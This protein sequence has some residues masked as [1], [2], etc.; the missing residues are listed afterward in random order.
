[1][2]SRRPPVDIRY[3][4]GIVL[5]SV[6]WITVLV[7]VVTVNYATDVHLNTKVVDNIKSSMVLKHDATSAIYIALERLL[8]RPTTASSSYNLAINRSTIEIEVKPESMKT[9]I[10]SANP[11]QL[12]RAFLDIG[13]DQPAAETLADRVIDW[14]DADHLST[15]KGMEDADYFANGSRYGAKDARFED[16]AELLLLEDIDA[17]TFQRIGDRFTTYAAKAG[18]LYTLSAQAYA[19]SKQKSY[20]VSTLVQLTFSSDRPYR[21]LKWRY[22]NS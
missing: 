15:L 9:D 2:S 10:N 6:L 1:M 20:R 7:I 22:N 21:I 3:G 4:R 11:D 18:K 17:S 13:L 5:P 12:R 14:R 8:S 16:L 19:D